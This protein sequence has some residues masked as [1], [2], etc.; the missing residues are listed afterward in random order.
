MIFFGKSYIFINFPVSKKSLN[1]INS[2]T[3][4][5]SVTGIAARTIET[6][7]PTSPIGI[8]SN[9]NKFQLE[10]KLTEASTLQ[11]NANTTADFYSYGNTYNEIHL[12]NGEFLH[13]IGMRGL[14]LYSSIIV[15]RGSAYLRTGVCNSS[16]IIL[17]SISVAK[18]ILS[19]LPCSYLGRKRPV[20]LCEQ[21]FQL[22]N[23]QRTTG[24]NC[25][26]SLILINQ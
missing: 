18:K 23:W 12:H 1:K 4:V 20:Q 13:N 25:I 11:R 21:C 10:N 3:F 22:F 24:K 26:I 9:E 15:P 2:F 16:L 17:F 5:Q 7:D 8:G 14:F 19:R 6:S